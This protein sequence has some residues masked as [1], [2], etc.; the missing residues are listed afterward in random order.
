MSHDPER[1]Y[2]LI[3]HGPNTAQI[4]TDVVSIDLSAAE[5]QAVMI[6]LGIAPSMMLDSAKGVEVRNA[7]ERLDSLLRR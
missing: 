6:V 5:M 3:V 1:P 2:T 4:L 7:L